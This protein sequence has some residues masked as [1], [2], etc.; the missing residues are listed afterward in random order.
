MS[1]QIPRSLNGFHQKAHK[2]P[3][4]PLNT[5]GWHDPLP[6]LPSEKVTSEESEPDAY[7]SQ[8]LRF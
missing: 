5:P 6:C 3:D 7:A 4:E 2:D 1:W 8:Q